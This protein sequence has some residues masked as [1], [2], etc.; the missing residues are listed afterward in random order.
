MDDMVIV[1]HR[2]ALTLCADVLRRAGLAPGDR[3]RLRLQGGGLVV[4]PARTAPRA[5]A[6]QAPLMAEAASV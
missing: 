4:E 5:P 2:G 3:V 1:D 6:G